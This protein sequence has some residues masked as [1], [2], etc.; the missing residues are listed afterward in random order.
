MRSGREPTLCINKMNAG[1]GPVPVGPESA[2]DALS[3]CGQLQDH[4][5]SDA[6]V[7]EAS[8]TQRGV[9]EPPLPLVTDFGVRLPLL[10]LNVR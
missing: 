1:A 4:F 9:I 3:G 10:L 8:N 7:L 5:Q 2:P 6:V